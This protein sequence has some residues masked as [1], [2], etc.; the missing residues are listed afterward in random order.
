M[1]FMLLSTLGICLATL[2]IFAQKGGS[3]EK[4]FQQ[5]KAVN[6]ASLQGHLE[7]NVDKICAAYAADA[8]LLPPDS[9]E[10]ISGAAAIKAYYTK[11]LQSGRLLKFSTE[12]ISYEVI[13]DRHTV[14]AGR[15]SLLFQPANAAQPI[16]VKG[17]MVIYW[18]RQPNQTWKIKLDMWR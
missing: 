7:Q 6:D 1:K 11:G 18:E 5:T 17:T 8:L 14:E 4:L 12:N 15:Y 13:D 10:P 2:G 3:K 16:E 9:P